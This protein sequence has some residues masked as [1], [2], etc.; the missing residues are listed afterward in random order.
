MKRIITATFLCLMLATPAWAGY[1]EAKAAY[2]RKDYAEALRELRPHV[3]QGDPKGQNVLGV[4]F[5]IGHGVARDYAAAATLFRKAADQGYAAAQT[6][7]G[8]A[9]NAGKG[10]PQDYAAVAPPEQ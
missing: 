5:K 3:E 7:L 4:M 8:F 1:E 2:E 6:N 9:Y 10:V